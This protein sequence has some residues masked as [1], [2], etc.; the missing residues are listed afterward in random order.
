MKQVF[1]VILLL[2]MG[3]GCSKPLPTFGEIP[4]FSL[5]NQEGESISKEDFL[6]S[7]WVANFV[8]TGCSDICPML[9]TQTIRLG[10]E[11]QEAGITG[12]KLVTFSV[13]PENDTPERLKSYRER[14]DG[15]DLEWALLTGPLDEVEKTVIHGFHVTMQKNPEELTSVLH[16]EKFVLMDRKAQ[17]RGYYDVDKLPELV[18]ALKKLKK[19][20]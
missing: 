4:D 8:Y 18:K 1:L 13:D 20:S 12:V 14:F 9:T 11:L 6:D 16:M 19:G 7:E 2:L 3:V 5:L 15:R 10:K 17:I